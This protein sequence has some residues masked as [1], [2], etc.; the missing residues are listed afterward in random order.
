MATV[1]GRM[2]KP[3]DG[4]RAL[5][6]M[7][8]MRIL[9]AMLVGLFVVGCGLEPA[10]GERGERGPAG[11][12]GARGEPGQRGDDGPQGV[13]GD[14]GPQNSLTRS[15]SRIR[16]RYLF[17][18]DGS[19]QWLGWSDTSTKQ[20]C[21]FVE[22]SDGLTRCLPEPFGNIFFLDAAC[23]SPIFATFVAAPPP[24]F[25]RDEQVPD[26]YIKNGAKQP[27]PS[28]MYIR[29]SAFQCGGQVPDSGLSFYSATKIPPSTFTEG[30][31][32]TE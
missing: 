2:R 5:A 12:V 6:T 17:G 16:G 29:S 14:P 4:G 27:A 15:G 21:R 9:G 13:V 32:V 7:D 23:T 28:M 22:A 8:P 26:L 1:P 11:A 3:L 25:I 30:T 20:T 10:A 24:E 31:L 18:D 19:R